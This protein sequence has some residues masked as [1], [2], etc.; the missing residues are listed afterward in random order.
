MPV[1]GHYTYIPSETRKTTDVKMFS[2]EYALL[3]VLLVD[4]VILYNYS[5]SGE[6]YILVVHNILY[7]MLIANNLLN[8][9]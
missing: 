2:P 7:V 5:F 1:V 3:N 8:Y 4:V 6:Q 9:L